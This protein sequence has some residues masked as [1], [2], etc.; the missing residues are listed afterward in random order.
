MSWDSKVIWSDGMFLRTHHFQQFDRYLEKLVRT[1]TADA[2]PYGW[3]V[4]EL[5]INR[6]LLSIGKFAVAHARGVFEDG[7]PFSIPDDVDHPPPL[8]VPPNT[9]NA[10]VSLTLPVRQPGSVE[11][12]IANSN[13]VVARYET[14]EFQAVDANAGSESV[15]LLRVGRLRV[16]YGLETEEL[17]GY[18]RIDIARISEVQS[19]GAILLDKGF[20][21]P[22]LSCATSPIVQG[23]LTELQ[24]LVEQRAEALAARLANNT[25]R[26]VADIA[27]F[28]LLQAVNRSA[29]LIA[30]MAGTTDLHPE[31]FYSEAVQM[32]GELATFTA[33]DKRPPHFPVYRHEDLQETFAPVMAALRQ[34]L[35]AI[36]ETN[37]VSI[38]LQERKFGIRVGQI[39][40]RNLISTAM[41][42]LAVKT[43]VPPEMLRR[44]FPT[45]VKI[46]PVE[47]I[48]ELVNV[49]LPGIAVRALPVAPR[50]IPYVA[51]ASYFELDRTGPLW[52][53]LANSGGVAIHLAGN[54]PE[55]EMSLW[56]IRS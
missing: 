9:R 18:T 39:N 30:H 49:A 17:Q 21:P 40:D 23:F 7:T 22:L 27:D 38:P 15:A 14:R 51:G 31:R 32:A 35:S 41:F 25:E 1:R 34:S 33:E 8:D 26:G 13:D 4:S 3:G 6:E 47:Q 50:Q 52:K 44:H 19:D 46:G 5:Q 45:Q 53:A 42:V 56:A 36:L 24:G 54:F 2:I 11:V 28:L 29:P 43:E 10:L 20:I 48:R 12:N 16:R 55:L 37:A